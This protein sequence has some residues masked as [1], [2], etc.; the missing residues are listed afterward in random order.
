MTPNNNN[1]TTEDI[2]LFRYNGEFRIISC[3][4]G[5][6]SVKVKNKYIDTWDKITTKW[7]DMTLDWEDYLMDYKVN[8]EKKRLQKKRANQNEL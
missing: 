1:F 4:I 8:T 2:L 3:S 5:N 6:R 7:E